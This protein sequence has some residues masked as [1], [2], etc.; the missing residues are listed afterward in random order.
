MAMCITAC[1]AACPTSA[2]AFGDL[3]DPDSAVS[4]AKNDP[5]NYTLLAELNT[6]PRTTYLSK[7][8]IANPELDE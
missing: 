7:L 8:R 1:Q 3:N 4:R 2:I 5:R 6:H